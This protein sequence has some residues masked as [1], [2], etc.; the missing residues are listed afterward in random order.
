MNILPGK[1]HPNAQRTGVIA[2]KV[3]MFPQYNE[4]YERHA[5]TCLWVFLLF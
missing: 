3:G 5:V 4:Y 2:I 1:W